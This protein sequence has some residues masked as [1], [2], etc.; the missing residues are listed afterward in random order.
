MKIDITVPEGVSGDWEVKHFTVSKE[1]EKTERLRAIF[2]SHGR[3]VPAGDYV[4]LYYKKTIVM[5]NTPDEI[6]DH[7][8][9]IHR[10]EGHV[11]LAGLGLGVVLQ[12]IANK[13]EVK[14]ITVIEK[15]EDVIKLVADHYKKMFLP[16]IFPG[17]STPN[18]LKMVGA[19]SYKAIC[20]VASNFL[21]QRKTPDK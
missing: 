20:F 18:S 17:F 7:Y 10:A 13:K 14:K 21:L 19:R 2:A 8:E 11:L 4:G 6:R 9:I 15:S 12:E 1:R 3:F 16:T 5:S